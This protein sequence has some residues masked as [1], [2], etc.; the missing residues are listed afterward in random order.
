MTDGKIRIGRIVPSSLERPARVFCDDPALAPY[1]ERPFFLAYLQDRIGAALRQDS[2]EGDRPADL[3]LS[4][5][6]THCLVTG[7]TGS[8]KSRAFALIID[9]HVRAGCSAVVVDP[10]GGTVDEL[11]PFLFRRGIPPDR[12]VLLDP[13]HPGSAP[14]FNFFLEPEVPLHEVIGNMAALIE[15]SYQNPGVRL[16][17]VIAN[18]LAVAGSHRLSWHE[19]A[20]L[21]VREGYWQQL[22]ERE[23]AAT[24]LAYREA[25]AFF[26]N[27]FG[28]WGKAERA[29][30]VTPVMTRFRELLRS[31][32]LFPL[33]NARRNTF[34][35]ASLW[36]RPQVVL[37]KLDR[38]GLGP[39]GE[40]LLASLMTEMLF[41]TA[42]RK[43]G[44]VPVVLAVDE[45][46]SVAR[47]VSQPLTSIVT[48]ARSQ[49]LRLLCATQGLEGI[50]DELRAALLANAAIKLYFGLGPADSRLV[51]ASLGV[52][53]QSAV[54]RVT[55]SAERLDR[56]TG[57]VPTA[58]WR[59]PV[60]GPDRKPL[61][62]DEA[63]WKSFLASSFTGLDDLWFVEQA[64]A[65]CGHRRL[66]V[67]C[68][69][70][71][72]HVAL[73]PYVEG[74]P[75]GS[76]RIEGPELSLRVTFPRPRITGVDKASEGDASGRIARTL[77]DLPV[78]HALVSV[79]ARPPVLVRIAD[80]VPPAVPRRD[81]SRYVRAI[82]AAHGPEMTAEELWE[83]REMGIG[84]CLREKPPPSS[85]GPRPEAVPDEP[86]PTDEAGLPKPPPPGAAG[87][88]GQGEAAHERKPQEEDD[89]SI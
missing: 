30:A 43:P 65:R 44:P 64:A 26:R 75:P 83:W 24:S 74:L 27:E 72:G 52:G 21:L 42:L 69:L 61:R 19:A 11:L 9:E 55:V 84:L 18:A 32:F 10:K 40:Q 29:S 16:R 13:A 7:R 2:H 79:A 47:L 89:D 87:E 22:L 85:R 6:G 58:D 31:P 46:A 73:R 56:E 67:R 5:F 86:A 28:R 17:E 4:A 54:E 36:R 63:G 66:Y 8:G 60:L 48:V 53:T 71:N 37:V 80:V 3:P 62:L 57:A 14:G 49:G 33:L 77:Q 12:I 38:V 1:A 51:A 39:L 76:F 70:G 59:H 88:D 82:R 25:C 41:R 20:Q 23:P 45:L 50:P 68:P 81:L 78:Q 15:E 34:S 35:F